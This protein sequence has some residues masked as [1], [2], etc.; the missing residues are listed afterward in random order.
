MIGNTKLTRKELD[1]FLMSISHPINNRP[2]TKLTEDSD[3]L[4][5][6]TPWM[7][8]SGIP[9]S[10]FPERDELRSKNLQTAYQKLKEIR[11]ALTERFR[12][13]YLAMIVQRPAEKGTDLL[14]VGDIVLVGQDN[15]KRFEWPLGRNLELFPG[16]D[17]KVRVAKVKTSTGELLRPVRRIY[18]LEVKSRENLEGEPEPFH[19]QMSQVKR[20]TRNA[21]RL[22]DTDIGTTKYVNILK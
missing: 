3:D 19:C 6:L 2:L 16:K 12:K 18:Q 5:P 1:K 17:G 15:K 7:F 14:A 21:M 8:M 22:D 11:R 13:E 4:I 20:G 9:M 10:G